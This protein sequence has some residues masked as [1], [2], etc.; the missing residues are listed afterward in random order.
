KDPGKSV[1]K[2]IT[3]PVKQDRYLDY[4]TNDFNFAVSVAAFGHLL[5][6]SSYKGNLSAWQV[7]A[8]ANDSLGKDQGG[9]RQEFITILDKYTSFMP[10]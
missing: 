5:R 6:N 7:M 9:Y 2:L 10:K 1:S 4:N 8:M 3:E